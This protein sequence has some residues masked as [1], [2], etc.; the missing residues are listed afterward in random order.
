M[1]FIKMQV[2]SFLRF[3]S[4][5]QMF[6]NYVVSTTRMYHSKIYRPQIETRGAGRNEQE[7][8]LVTSEILVLLVT[9]SN[10]L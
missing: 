10:Y 1:F 7:G 9:R 4:E 2:T 8:T 3:Y 5:I 6:K